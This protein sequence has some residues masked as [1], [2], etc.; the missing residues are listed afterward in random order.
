MLRTYTSLLRR[1]ANARNV[2]SMAKP[3]RRKKMSYQP[4]LIKPIY[5]ANSLTQ[6]KPAFFKTSLPVLINYPRLRKNREELL[7]WIRHKIMGKNLFLGLMFI[8]VTSHRAKRAA[9]YFRWAPCG[10]IRMPTNFKNTFAKSF[11]RFFPRC[12]PGSRLMILCCMYNCYQ[13]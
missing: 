3:H 4:L 1:R 8:S 6:K 9:T 11:A 2:S 12:G 13:F 10:L 5:S 7:F